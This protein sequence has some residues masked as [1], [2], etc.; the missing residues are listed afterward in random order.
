MRVGLSR[1]L[2]IGVVLV[3]VTWNACGQQNNAPLSGA[4]GEVRIMTLDP[5]HFHASLV[6]KTMYDQVS[7]TVYVFA[8]EGP[9]LQD[10]LKR[11]QAFNTRQTDPTAWVEKVYTGP[12]FLE[13]MIQ[14]KPGNVVVISGNNARKTDYIFNSVQ[15]GLNVLA[16]K[17]MVITPEKF[18]L[19]E[20]A[21]TT[22]QKKGVLLYD[23][24]TE[25]YEITTILQ[26]ELAQIPEVFGTLEKGTPEDPAVTK[27]SVHHFY[28]SVAGSALVRPGWFFDVRQQGEGMVDVSTHL[29]DLIQWECFPEQI[30]R[31][32]DIKMLAAKRWPTSLSLSQYQEV[33][34]LKAFP[35]FLN[36]AVDSNQL[37][38]YSNGQMTYTLKGVH[39]RVS[40]AWNYRAPEG[41]G[42]THKSVLRGTRS[43][44]VI[45]QDKEEKYE[46]TLYVEARAGSGF[47]AALKKAVAETLQAKY[48]GI[49]LQPLS[50]GKWRIDIPPKYRVGHE[51]HFGQVTERF[52]RYLAQGKLPDWE[53]PNMIA[54]YYTTTEALRMARP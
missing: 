15:A 12:D 44:L 13:K 48:P 9:D 33:T 54:K 21:F 27:E 29:V 10:H 53:V 42:D 40:V 30:I 24:M 8:P 14:E 49:S 18:P 6:Q 36:D 43:S 3:F 32:A 50:E 52:L 34:G 47:D 39:A 26:K 17:P 38:V 20:E 25:R 35:A 1:F 51:A 41:A 37:K 31:K 5:G 45:R 19:L 46:P 7:P 11:I 28:K 23:I 4:K 22:A 2:Q 16:D